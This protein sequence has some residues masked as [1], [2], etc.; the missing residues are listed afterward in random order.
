[1]KK[2]KTNENFISSSHD[3]IGKDYVI[4]SKLWQLNNIVFSPRDFTPV[5]TTELVRVVQLEPGFRK[6]NV[7][8][9]SLTNIIELCRMR[10]GDSDTCCSAAVSDNSDDNRFL[11]SKLGMMDPDEYDEKGA[12][13]TARCIIGPE[14]TLKLSI[15]YPA[16]RGEILRVVD[17]LQL[18][19]TKLVA[20]PVD[21]QNGDDRVMVP[22][23]DDNEAKKLL[24]R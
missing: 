12:A 9:I 24:R 15:L 6:R 22:T 7:K 2:K 19:A 11:A 4:I 16:T 1:M 23:I 13:L 3:W 10:S 5:C 20:I 14:K 8:L 21:W 17:S 18:T